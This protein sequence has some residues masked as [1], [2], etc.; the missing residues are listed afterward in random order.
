MFN[1]VVCISIS[2]GFPEPCI[3]CQLGK[4]ED[5]GPA[6]TGLAE[7]VGLSSFVDGSSGDSLTP[8][9]DA[10]VSEEAEGAEDC[11]EDSLA[12]HVSELR[13]VPKDEQSLD[14]IFRSFS[15]MA[16]LHP[17]LDESGE[18]DAETDDLEQDEKG[19]LPE[20]DGASSSDLLDDAEEEEEVAALH[21]RQM[22][23]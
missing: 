9:G 8:V 19:W 13:F 12:E 22:P 16:A 5:S 7:T 10:A 18:L 15:E 3:Y 4:A 23:Q 21:G 2:D 17:D 1:S 14:S 11:D 20:D 6:V